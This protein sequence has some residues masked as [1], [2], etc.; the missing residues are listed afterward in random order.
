[1]AKKIEWEDRLG[2]ELLNIYPVR[3]NPN[4]ANSHY[5]YSRLLGGGNK[6]I[7]SILLCH[8]RTARKMMPGMFMSYA[9]IYAV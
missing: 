4:S 3:Q 7:P 8:P 5:D 2:M 1:M 6:N 9:N